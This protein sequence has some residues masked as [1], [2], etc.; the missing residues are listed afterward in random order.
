MLWRGER[1]IDVRQVVPR[2]RDA[3]CVFEHIY[4]ARPDSTLEGRLV[5]EARRGMGQIPRRAAPA[6]AEHAGGCSSLAPATRLPTWTSCWACRT[7]AQRRR[8][9]M[10]RRPASRVRTA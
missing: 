3:F 2:T 4:F 9:A 10:R 5:Y 1:G 6:R 8:T 7:P